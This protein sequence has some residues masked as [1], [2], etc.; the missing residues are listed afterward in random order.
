VDESGGGHLPHPVHEEGHDDDIDG[1]HLVH[2]ELGVVEEGDGDQRSR[3]DGQPQQV[4][5][6]V[7]V[8]L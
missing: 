5:G 6:G 7:Q 2:Y 4:D 1:A 8:F 3:G